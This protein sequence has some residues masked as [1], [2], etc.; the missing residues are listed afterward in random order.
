MRSWGLSAVEQDEV[1][2]GPET[3][4]FAAYGRWRAGNAGLHSGEPAI[5][6]KDEVWAGLPPRS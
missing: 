2:T 4:N 3:H 5:T 1:T 6:Y